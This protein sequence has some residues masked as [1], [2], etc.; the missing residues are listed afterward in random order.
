[1]S[2][3]N[4]EIL[5]ARLYTD[6]RFRRT[7]LAEPEATA[8]AH[9]LDDAEVAALRDIDHDGLALASGSFA[10]KRAAHSH[11]RRSWLA[12]LLTRT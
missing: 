10:R 9:G 12:R 6:A 1:V 4:L 5:L 11:R 2:A 3:A 7:F 8:R